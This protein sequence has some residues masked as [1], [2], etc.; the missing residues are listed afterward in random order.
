MIELIFAIIIISIAVVSL[1]VMTKITEK[2]I[3]EGILQEAIFA[4]A[5]TLML[6]SSAYWDER[7]MEDVNVSYISRVVD[8]DGDCNATTRLRPGHVAQPLHRRC[9]YSNSSLHLED[10]VDPDIFAL[11]DA[12]VEIN[13]DDNIFKNPGGEAQGYKDAYTVTMVTGL[14]TDKNIKDINVTV[15]HVVDTVKTPITKLSMQSANVGEI[16]YFKRRF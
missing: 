14:H 1:P 5:S 13:N 15:Y 9:L 3:E 7:S 8:V 16:D 4:G 11:E 2:G 6:V 12:A 10:T